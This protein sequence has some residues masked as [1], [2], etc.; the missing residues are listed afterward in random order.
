M[1]V[2]EDMRRPTT[3][4][5]P[6]VSVIVPTYNAEAY[7]RDCLDSLVAQTL[8]SIEII[9]VDDASIDR[10]LEIMRE[11][12][13][14]DA[15]IKVQALPCNS[16]QGAARNLGLA[17]ATA[18]YIGF[19]DAD[20]FVS[21]EY[22]ENLYRAIVGYD[23]DVVITAYQDVDEGGK[24]FQARLRC[25]KMFRGLFVGRKKQETGSGIW[26]RKLGQGWQRNQD[27]SSPLLRMR[28]AE[29]FMVMNKL[30]RKSLVQGLRFPEKMRFEDVPFTTEVMHRA[31]RVFTTPEGGYYYRQHRKA[32]THNFQFDFQK[33]M[34]HLTAFQMM[35]TYLDHA[36]MEW[37]AKHTALEIARK[38]QEYI[39]RKLVKNNYWQTVRQIHR[40]EKLVS[41]DITLFLRARLRRRKVN[42][43]ARFV[44]AVILGY[45]AYRCL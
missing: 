6:L 23:A 38:S 13:C 1:D 18:P 7:L 19:V 41:A 3:A 40:V 15:R 21:P 44:L 5:G 39:I 26:E 12:A 32:T 30:Y 22:F 14:R 11:Y 4:A 17:I 42:F 16:R 28:C 37:E 2:T 34:E 25:G 36:D 10:S 45:T 9:C 8:N 33:Q 24:I 43:T 27:Y 20:D 31:G 35:R 29:Q